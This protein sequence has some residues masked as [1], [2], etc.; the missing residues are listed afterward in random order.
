MTGALSPLQRLGNLSAAAGGQEGSGKVPLR[1]SQVSSSLVVY[2]VAVLL[3]LAVYSLLRRKC[4]SV[5]TPRLALRDALLSGS[6]AA[7]R[8]RSSL[9]VDSVAALNS[10]TVSG[11]RNSSSGGLEGGENLKTAWTAVNCGLCDFDLS[12]AWQALSLRE[13]DLIR[14]CG[15]DGYV[16]LRIV[17][18]CWAVT[19]AYCVVAILF[20]FPIYAGQP[21]VPRCRR[22]CEMEAEELDLTESDPWDAASCICTV[23]DRSS[24]ANVPIGS[25]TLWT[26]VLVIYIFTLM[27]LWAA[28]LE[29]QAMVR[30]K[31]HYWASTPPEAYSVLVEQIPLRLRDKSGHKIYEYFERMFPEH[32]FSVAMID[33]GTQG[34]RSLINTGFDRN[35]VLRRLERVKALLNIE[36]SRNAEG[37]CP[38]S[39]VAKDRRL[40]S[41][42]RTRYDLE[43]QLELLNGR[44]KRDRNF[45][46]S[47]VV[48]PKEE[49]RKSSEASQVT[50]TLSALEDVEALALGGNNAKEESNVDEEDIGNVEENKDLLVRGYF[51]R[52]DDI[53]FSAAF[54]TFNRLKPSAI[55]SQS[56][57]DNMSDMSVV[58]APEP[59]D[60]SW[61]N[62]GMSTRTRMLRRVVTRAIFFILLLFW[63]VFT[64]VIGASTSTKALAR[65]IPALKA[66]LAQ[67]PNVSQ[68]LDMLAPLVLISLLSVVNPLMGLMARFEGRVSESAAD[69][70]ALERYFAFLVIQV[71]LFYSVAGTV[72][73]T[74]VEILQQPS[75]IVDTLGNTIPKN[76]S[77]Y[78][79]F[80]IVKFFWMLAFELLRGADIILALLRRIVA[81]KPLTERERLSLFCGCFEMTYPTPLNISSTLAQLLLVYFIAIV[82]SVIQPLILPT[83]FVFF[84]LGNVVYTTTITSASEQMYDSGGRFWWNTA[85]RCIV[86]G[87][88]TSQLT[89]IGVLFIKQ[90]FKQVIPMWLLV[91][92]TLFFGYKLEARFAPL[93][94]NLSVNQA[95]FLDEVAPA[96][97]VQIR[98]PL[99]QYGSR[100]FPHGIKSRVELNNLNSPTNAN[101]N[102]LFV[103]NYQHPVLQEEEVIKAN[104]YKGATHEQENYGTL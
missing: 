65:Q 26:P 73:K 5:M 71:F 12:W 38:D 32:V 69:K 41:L 93:V 104:P 16:F 80:V 84:A 49:L 63:G 4:R 42:R 21:V 66:Y 40:S 97:T 3:S 47:D 67:N 78:I 52:D 43:Y 87:L 9:S 29:Y 95:A 60:V 79:Q 51:D 76:A 100:T 55:A 6:R 61:D 85:Y 99:W 90:G 92:A 39:A 54:V 94:S 27:T 58:P 77:F 33:S 75:R 82:Y 30:M 2:T 25:T 8:D 24:M 89:L 101:R 19:T 72:F 11:R 45:Y 10:S 17:R 74:F 48:D 1:G 7:E 102:R 15:M 22:F 34:F 13:A 37:C 28:K 62:I 91:F 88:V 96:E 35:D 59:L 53:Y 103:Y 83:T 86:T 44:F 81:G 68:Y 70:R 14:Q 57:I 64:S 36:G 98:P 31:N 18:F 46:L 50:R 23:I 20:L 56:Q